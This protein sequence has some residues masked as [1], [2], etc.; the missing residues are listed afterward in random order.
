M[1]C[2]DLLET[3]RVRTETLNVADSTGETPCW[4]PAF[5]QPANAAPPQ[6]C[7]LNIADRSARASLYVPVQHL[8]ATRQNCP[9]RWLPLYRGRRKAIGCRRCAASATCNHHLRNC[10]NT[11][12]SSV[13][14]LAEGEGGTRAS[15]SAARR[16]S[17]SGA[18]EGARA[19]GHPEPRYSEARPGEQH[20]CREHHHHLSLS[21]S[22]RTCIRL[23][24]DIMSYHNFAGSCKDRPLR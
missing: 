5:L 6:L 14:Q 21:L 24:S 13:C 17:S 11:T 7:P 22:P 19:G 18:P 8:S 12:N 2:Q 20:H 3:E 16:G 10:W 23:S 1:D 15:G 4:R 9:L